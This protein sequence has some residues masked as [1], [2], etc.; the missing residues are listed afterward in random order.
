VLQI[1]SAEGCDDRAACQAIA[2]LARPGRH[3]A[4]DEL[5]WAVLAAAGAVVLQELDAEFKHFPGSI[6]R[7]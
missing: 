5:G 2:G 3:A 4:D 6:T 7:R 1:V